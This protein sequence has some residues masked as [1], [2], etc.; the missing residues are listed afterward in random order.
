MIKI[1]VIDNRER[2]RAHLIE[3]L[4][5]EQNLIVVAEGSFASEI[6]SIYSEYRPEII[7]MEIDVNFS[8]TIETIEYLLEKHPKVKIIA[9][10][11]Q[12]KE[13]FV[14]ESIR[15][16][17]SAYVLKEKGIKSIVEAINHVY[18]GHSFIHPQVTDI[19]LKEYQRL[20]FLEFKVNL[21]SGK[22]FT[23]NPTHLLS[24]REC[25]ILQLLAFGNSNKAI[26]ETIYISEK[27]VKNHVSSILSK[28][29][30]NDRTQAV[31]KAI[32]NG[33]VKLD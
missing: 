19:V 3:Q 7:L 12:E 28:M 14:K 13:L 29:K 27:T 18:K 21:R 16:G 30:V 15:A 2:Y 23:K 33:W 22:G 31:V 11:N 25:E 6:Y 10:T 1:A 5:Y 4:H 8:V 32:K 20:S 9:L 26:G 24:K 17:V